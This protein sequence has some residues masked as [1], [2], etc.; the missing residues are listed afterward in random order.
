MTRQLVAAIKAL[1]V[2]TLVCGVGYPAVVLLAAQLVPGRAAG[3]PV[4]VDGREVGSHLLGHP[5]GGPGWFQGRPSASD[6]SGETSGG[7]NLGPSNP[8]VAAAVADR[9]TSLRAANPDAPTTIPPDALTT[10][11]SG[12]DPDISPAYALWQV[13]RIAKVRGLDVAVVRRI[14]TDRVEDAPLGML[15]QA[16]VNVLALNVA[17][18]ARTSGEE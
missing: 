5:D 1:L 2:L 16:R 17:L 4:L 15:G 12:L 7:S 8:D 18:D 6:A 10:S 3:Q 14:V 11:A 9:T 13:P